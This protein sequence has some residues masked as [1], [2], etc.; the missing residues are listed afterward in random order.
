MN[1]LPVS[2]PNPTHSHWDT[3]LDEFV[4]HTHPH[5]GA[6][7]HIT[8]NNRSTTSYVPGNYSPVAAR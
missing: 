5:D 4:T 7:R 1:G 2:L 8:V 6:H 3:V